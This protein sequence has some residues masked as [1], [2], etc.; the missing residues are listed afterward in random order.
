MIYNAETAPGKEVVSSDHPLSLGYSLVLFTQSRY[1]KEEY[2]SSENEISTHFE[3][4]NLDQYEGMASGFPEPRVYAI[5]IADSDDISY[6]RFH[7][8]LTHELS[9]IVDYIFEN[10][11]IANIDTELRA[12]YLDYLLGKVLNAVLVDKYKAKQPSDPTA[13]VLEQSL[14][15]TGKTYLQSAAAERGIEV[16][17]SDDL[18][19]AFPDHHERL[20]EL[21]RQSKSGQYDVVTSSLWFGEVDEQATFVFI[22]DLD[23]WLNDVKANRP[24]LIEAFSEEKLKSWHSDYI[25]AYESGKF[26]GATVYFGKPG[27]HLLD[28][29]FN[30]A[31]IMEDASLSKPTRAIIEIEGL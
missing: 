4:E 16:L 2:R 8:L 6:V 1:C 18:T 22:P 24:D 11:C 5:F 7:E 17:D 9:H 14:P 25:K 12:Y 19:A 26:G 30:Q 27:E 10:C 23:F 31:L 29:P 28:A 20:N 3:D 13:V 15:G 21:V